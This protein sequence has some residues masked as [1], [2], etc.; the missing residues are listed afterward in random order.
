MEFKEVLLQLSTYPEVCPTNAID[1]AVEFSELLRA[2]I[3]ALTFEIEFY[4]PGNVLANEAV[5]GL[6]GRDI[7]HI[8]V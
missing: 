6:D 7:G 3:S 4:M 8:F 1:Q 2:R 5:G